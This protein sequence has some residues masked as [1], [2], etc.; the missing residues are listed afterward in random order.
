VDETKVYERRWWALVALAGSL[1]VITLDNTI[2]NVAIPSLVEDLDASTSELQWI[3]DG[4]VIVF[5]GLLLTCGALGDRFGRKGMLQIGLS[6]FGLASLWSSM[7]DSPTQLIIARAV[8]GVGGAMIMPSTLSL[9]T[10]IFRD[11]KE[12]G[13]AIGVWA[14]V[15]GASGALGPVLG[16]LLLR[17]FGWGSVFLVNVPI[18]ITML[19]AGKF[20]LPTSKAPHATR[21]DPVGAVLSIA[22]LV[23][24]LF[25]VIETPI[26]GWTDPM[27]LAAF[28]IGLATL[29]GFILWELHVAEPMLD[30]RFFANPRFT[31]ANMAITL[32]FFAMFGQMFVMT[33]YLQIVLGYEALE[34][35]LRMLPMSVVMLTTAPLAPRIVEKI[36]TKLVVGGGLCLVAVGV[37]TLS[38][39]PVTDGYPRVIT[40]MIILAFGMALT[41]APA[42]ESIMGSLPPAKAGI[43]SAMNDTTRQMGG[44]LG[45]AV[46]GSI[47]AGVYR[48]AVERGLTD[49]GIADPALGT[50]V[51]SVG[52]ALTQVAPQLPA[53]VG[54]Q[55]V[56]VAAAAYVD[57]AHLAMRVGG[58]VILVAAAVVFAFLPARAKDAREDE[59]GP[60]D[61]L[62]SLTWAEA[63]GVLEHDAALERGLIGSD[64]DPRYDD[65]AADAARDGVGSATDSG[66]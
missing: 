1:L 52:G 24:L 38:T 54:A 41:M 18:I 65:G 56:N 13:R 63:E 22:A 29:V 34:A 12:R 40:G 30:M 11:A 19:I 26:K 8:M 20:L 2:L 33:Q 6:I 60:L 64:A 4:Y 42:T 27:V 49:I 21:L 66:R 55:V 59:E 37:F 46:L 17:W 16:G 47:L 50:A 28:G 35:G 23:A 45:V 5:A 51:D 61:G 31:A 58:V 36:G 32:V 15:A 57:G 44:A 25:G 3:I 39:I 10:N 53:D 43:G 48:P 14:A 7:A 62:A 9:L